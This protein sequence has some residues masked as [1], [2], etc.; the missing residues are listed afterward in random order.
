M[1]RSDLISL[2]AQRLP[3]AA[4]RIE[5][6]PNNDI[7]LQVERQD[8]IAVVTIL[9]KDRELGFNALTNQLGV[10]YGDRF[11]VI[12]NLYSFAIDNKLTVKVFLEKEDPEIDSIEQLFRGANWFE[13]ET[14]DLLGIRFKGHGNLERLLLPADWDGHPLRKDYVYP[15]TYHSLG[16]K[17]KTLFED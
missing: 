10:D 12:C 8:F 9:K 13:R 3:D 11:A 1:Q 14:Y 2:L 4:V 6:M 17:R 15:E 16:L 7:M 5:E